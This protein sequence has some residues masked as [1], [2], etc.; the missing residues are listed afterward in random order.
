MK[1]SW[2]LILVLALMASLIGCDDEPATVD[3][4]P[5]QATTV[6]VPKAE[7]ST[8]ESA[9]EV[10]IN[11]AEVTFSAEAPERLA[12]E[13]EASNA[14]NYYLVAR[15]KLDSFLQ[16][17]I[18]SGD[19]E[20][21]SALLDDTIEAFEK[22]EEISALLEDASGNL[23][24][25]EA[26][27]S[28][29]PSDGTGTYRLI[30]GSE[31]GNDDFFSLNP[32]MV[33]VYA[34]EESEAVKWAKDITERFDNAPAGKGIRTLAEQMGTDAKHAYAQLKQAQDILSGAAYDDFAQTADTAYKTAMALKT[35]GTAAQLT[36]S[37]VTA[38]PA[39]MT[40]AVLAGGGILMNGINTVLEV[41]QTGSVL[42]VGD[43]NKVSATL[44]NIENALAPIGSTIGLFSLASNVAKGAEFLKDTPAMADSMMYIGTSLNDYLSNGK[45]LGGM[46]TQQ[47]DGT[48][49]CTLSDTMTIKNQW[50]KAPEQF[51]Q[52]LTAVGY[53]DSEI[54]ALQGLGQ[55]D[56]TP[57]DISSIISQEDIDSILEEI[58]P[59][60]TEPGSATEAIM[61]SVGDSSD[62]TAGQGDVSE[63]AIDHEDDADD[64]TED[65]SDASS[66]IPDISELS[67]RYPFYVYMTM[68]DQSADG[69]YAQTISFTGGSSLEMTDDSGLT[70][71][72]TYDASS[73]VG[74][75]HDTDGTPVKVTFTRKDNGKIHAV[76]KIRA[77]YGTMDGEADRN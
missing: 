10:I 33:T 70:L 19:P 69:E 76:I 28:F 52:V 21:Y 43:D 24:K 72:G 39:T 36:L 61:E 53:T 71:S 4:Q 2:T 41:G 49:A 18:E 73:G 23:E 47:A 34:A 64:H 14:I 12:V 38:N 27:A 56:T 74:T 32:F 44:E 50:A 35:A 54:T 11:T 13:A 67:G 77:E 58:T 68:G 40:E 5:S 3:E 8:E 16:Y 48:L 66:T 62:D 57:F 9:E 30:A 17:D 6:E 1:K 31:T 42:I 46:F 55:A 15:M 20:E 60:L 51:S 65:D 29:L 59:L 75:F 63:D 25:L 26:K 37:V 22:V 45:I 7:P